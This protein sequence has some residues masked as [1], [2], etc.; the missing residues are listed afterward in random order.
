MTTSEF[1]SSQIQ[2]SL[3]VHPDGHVLAAT[4]QVLV[5]YLT[6]QEDIDPAFAE[7]F[8]GTFKSFMT[9]NELLNALVCQYCKD[10]PLGLTSA[11]VNEWRNTKQPVVRARVLEVVKAMLG[12][13]SILK[14][15]D[16]T[17]LDRVSEFLSEPDFMEDERASEL[18]RLVPLA[19]TRLSKPQEAEC[20]TIIS[21]TAKRRSL[22]ETEP[23]ELA[24]QLTLMDAA[25]YKQVR[26]VDC[27]KRMQA[28]G[29][30]WATD[31]SITPVIGLSNKI[32]LWVGWSVLHEED[33]VSRVATVTYLIDVAKHCRDSH[34]FSSM[35]DILSGLNSPPV[36]RLKA[37]WAGVGAESMAVMQACESTIDVAGGLVAYRSTLAHTMPPCVPFIGA[38]LTLLAQINGAEDNE[39]PERLVDFGKLR[40]AYPI[41]QEIHR[42]QLVPYGIE[43]IPAVASYLED[44]LSEIGDGDAE[45]FPMLQLSFQIETHRPE[46]EE[47]EKFLQ[48]IEG[49]PGE[50]EGMQ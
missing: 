49:S 35:T 26:V 14:Q 42:F 7:V 20:A 3:L 40:K 1:S 46:D 12:D 18:A 13:N 9:V 22:R 32:A 8:L 17:V 31:D 41:L 48:A 25:L 45:V 21:V 44:A 15:D 10:V 47:L 11:E 28:P 39:V 38:Y 34:N 24:E 37:T 30:A 23:H 5:E 43:P 6:E 36:R 33:L 2:P 19:Q 29:S 50:V 4:P 16:Q 27:L